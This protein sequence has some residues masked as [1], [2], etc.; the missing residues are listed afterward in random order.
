[1]G[2]PEL[3]IFPVLKDKVAIITGG[4]Q[5]QGKATAA[6]FLKGGAKVV[7]ADVKEE[8]GIKVAEE[9]SSLGEIKWP[10]SADPRKC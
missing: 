10:T 1:M 9:L 8:Q 3:E 2:A 4:A 5:G 7:I 6:V